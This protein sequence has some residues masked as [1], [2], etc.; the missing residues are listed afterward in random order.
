MLKLVI[1][2]PYNDYPKPYRNYAYKLSYLLD[3]VQMRDLKTPYCVQYVVLQSTKFR[4][5]YYLNFKS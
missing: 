2:Y 4:K 1:K 5:I 3:T